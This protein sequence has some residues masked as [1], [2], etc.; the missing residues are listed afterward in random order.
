[1]WLYVFK[2]MSQLRE[3]PKILDK[4][5][6]SLIFDIG[7]VSNLKPEDMKAY[8]SSLKNKRDAESVRI[9]AVRQGLQEGLEKGLQQGRIEERAKA[10]AEK[11]KSAL[12]FK[13][14]GL[15]IEDIAKGLGLSVEEIEK[16]K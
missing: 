2:H 10:K 6:F 8:E 1:M 7:E 14:M 12:N 11:L 13:K 16:L 3:I 9:T 4:R 5:V 15:P